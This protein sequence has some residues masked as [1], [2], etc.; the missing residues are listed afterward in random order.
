MGLKTQ[1]LKVKFME[2]LGASV[3]SFSP[4]STVP[5]AFPQNL[6]GKVL[7]LFSPEASGERCLTHGLEL[8]VL[9]VII[10]TG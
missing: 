9:T 7:N 10:N 4:G 5:T 3:S 1:N 6:L 8:T 2:G